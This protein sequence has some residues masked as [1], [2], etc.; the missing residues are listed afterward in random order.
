MATRRITSVG[1]PLDNQDA[2]T[3]R[4]CDTNSDAVIP[5]FLVNLSG[6]TL[7]TA[8]SMLTG[9][10]T[11]KVMGQTLTSPCAVFS[12]SKS[13][14]SSHPQVNRVSAS[15]GAVGPTNLVLDWPVGGNILVGKTTASYD[16]TYLVSIF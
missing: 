2:S 11:I 3:K 16:G 8:Y 9:T 13:T 15:P 7:A 4:Y 14:S 6:T 5:K 12:V 1:D 10:F